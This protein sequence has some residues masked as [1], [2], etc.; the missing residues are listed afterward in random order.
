M[1]KQSS[2]TEQESALSVEWCQMINDALQFRTTNLLT[3]VFLN[4][5]MISLQSSLHKLT[6]NSMPA[7]RV[8]FSMQRMVLCDPVKPLGLKSA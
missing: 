7:S 6:L 8:H 5:Y 2:R 3:K 4:Y 1:V